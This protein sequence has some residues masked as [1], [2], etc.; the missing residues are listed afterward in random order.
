MISTI[1][2]NAAKFHGRHSIFF[3]ERGLIVA[4][5]NGLALPVRFP[6]DRDE[7]RRNNRLDSVNILEL[8]RH[9]LYSHPIVIDNPIPHNPFFKDIKITYIYLSVIERIAF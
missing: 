7:N 2:G 5:A 9:L 6:T 1:R 4:G 8:V 3:K